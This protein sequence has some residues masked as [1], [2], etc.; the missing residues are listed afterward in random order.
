M[1]LH[2][3]SLQSPF[4][5][6]L[7]GHISLD[8]WLN[9]Q[10]DNEK[11][12]SK[13]PSIIEVARQYIQ[14][15]HAEMIVKKPTLLEEIF[16]GSISRVPLFEFPPLKCEAMFDILALCIRNQPIIDNNHEHKCIIINL[17]RR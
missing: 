15:K 9:D 4:D 10:N 8:L 7:C 5:L 2:F 17:K 11:D 3:V 12:I 13:F 16:K 1:E 6:W 14:P